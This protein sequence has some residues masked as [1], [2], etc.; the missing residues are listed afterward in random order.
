VRRAMS[1]NVDHDRIALAVVLLEIDGRDLDEV[2][3][4]VADEDVTSHGN[5][6]V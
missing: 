1:L 2:L 5:I 3:E 4:L 6:A